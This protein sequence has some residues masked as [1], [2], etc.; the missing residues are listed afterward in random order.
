MNIIYQDLILMFKYIILEEI[1]HNDKFSKNRLAIHKELKELITILT[2]VI[3][4]HSLDFD[5]KLSFDL[6]I[7]LCEDINDLI[8][9]EYSF[10]SYIADKIICEDDKIVTLILEDRK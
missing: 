2:S 9:D 8:L 1:V 4:L 3:R 6:K 10:D 7:K 5:I